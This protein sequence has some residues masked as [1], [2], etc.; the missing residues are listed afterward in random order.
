MLKIL[1]KGLELYDEK[2]NEFYY[3]LKEPIE[4]QLEHSLVSISKWE[5]KY[6]KAFLV[7][8]P[9]KTSEELMYYI[10]CMTLT[11]NVSDNVYN[12]LSK[13]NIDEI[14]K[15]IEDPMTATTF[16]EENDNKKHNKDLPTSEFIYFLMISYGIPF[17]CQKWHINRLMALINVCSKKNQPEKKLKTNDILARN[18]KLNEARRK[19]LHTRG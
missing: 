12:N 14:S 17:E 11:Q 15:Y 10:K 18:R 5:S 1:I 13:E 4:I 7:K 19:A 2:T 8:E 6:H 16:Y 3:S 9:K